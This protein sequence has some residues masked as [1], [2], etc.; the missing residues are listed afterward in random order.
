MKKL[1][2]IFLTLSGVSLLMFSS[3]KKNDA[4]VVTKGGTAGTLAANSTTI[5]LSKSRLSDTASVVNFT[6]SKPNYGFNAAATNTLQIDVASDNWANPISTTMATR[7]SSQG[8]NT[9]DFNAMLLKLNLQGGVASQVVARVQSSIVGSALKPI[10]SNTVTLTVTP[11]Y[12]ISYVYLPGTYQNTDNT[13][14][15]IPATADSLVSP[16]G[17]GVYTGYVHFMG[18]DLFKVTPAKNWNTSYGDAGSGN[19]STSG[20]NITGPSTA[21]LYSVT[22]DLNKNTISWTLSTYNHAWS[23]IG[24]AAVSWSTDLDMPFNQN[25]NSYQVTTALNTTG[26][27]KFRADHDWTLSLGSSSTP[28]TLTSNNGGN[29]SVATAGTYVVSL[30]FGDP[31]HAPTYTAVKQ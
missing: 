27:F 20:G 30:S 2:T 19:I 11:F 16:T 14:Q 3:C 26:G 8:F 12:L 5:P 21:G 17:N 31:L 18:G 6:Y 4:L 22:V 23:L 9:S 10:Y 29:L 13:K 28:P 7:A 24:D 1:F 25:A 15:W